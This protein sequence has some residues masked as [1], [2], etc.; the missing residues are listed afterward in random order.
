MVHV[1]VDNN[2]EHFTPRPPTSESGVSGHTPGQTSRS[3]RG[4][5]ADS[6]K[7]LLDDD[8]GGSQRSEVASLSQERT[9][10]A[11]PWWERNK[12]SLWVVERLWPNIWHFFESSFPEPAKERSFQKEVSC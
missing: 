1:V 8:E 12:A 10:H 2:F 3:G 4:G 6:G 11:N 7:D 9:G 5:G